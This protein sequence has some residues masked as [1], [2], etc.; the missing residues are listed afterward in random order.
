MKTKSIFSLVAILAL[1]FS[2]GKNK[3]ITPSA[4]FAPYIS[5]YTGGQISSNSSI[6]IE[7]AKEFPMV[8]LNSEVKES[9]FSFSPSLKGKAYWINNKTI[10]FVPDSG[11]LQRGKLYNA[12]FKLGKVAEVEKKLNVFPFSFQVIEQN[13]AIE[14]E[15]YS[16][17]GDYDTEHAM[18]EGSLKLSDAAD[19]VQVKKMLSADL[20]G[21]GKLPVKVEAT[22]DLK[23]YHFTIENIP[24]KKE[25]K[26]LE[27]FA[28]GNPIEVNRSQK[29]S[30]LIP[31][32]GSFRFLSAS[33][34][35][36]P[37][38]GIEIV[39]SDPISQTQ[40]LTGLISLSEVN[41]FTYQIDKNKV[42]LFFEYGSIKNV[43]LNIEGTVKNCQ[44]KTLGKPVSLSLNLES[45]K[46]KVEIPFSG[47]ILPDSKNLA[48][49][50]KAVNLW[51]VD[52]RIVQIY[53]NNLLTFFQTN[54]L[55]SS[56][57]LRRFGRL[58]FKKTL[59]LDGDPAKRL[60]RWENFS[61]D[62]SKII[63]Q[64][65]GAIYRIELSFKKEYSLYPC[66]GVVPKKLT[67]EGLTAISPEELDEKEMAEWDRTSP[68]YYGSYYE[69]EDWYDYRWDEQDDPC[70]SSYYMNSDLKASCNVFASNMGI[71]VK[72]NS[73]KQMW[74]TVANIL[75]AKPMSGT[76][77]KIYNYQ[78]Q[79]IGSGKTDKDG[80]ATIE[81]NPK[82][83]KPFIAYAESGNEKA[84]LRLVDGEEKS[85]SRFDVGGKE[86][87][88]GLK[89]YIYGER[90]V[91]RPGDTVHLGFILEDKQKKI[92]ANHPVT[93]EI[94][95]PRGQF[96][97]KHISTE[98]LNGFYRFDIPTR[99]D[100]PTGLWS[101][102]IKIGGNTF[103]KSLR[104]ETVKPN[105]L[106]VNLEI[107]SSII[108]ASSGSIDATLTSNWLTGATARNLKAKVEM[109]FSKVNVPFKGYESYVF[110]NP[111]SRLYSEN[112]EIF[113]GALNEEGVARFSMRI[114]QAENAPG[115]LKATL[116]SRVFEPGGD[117]SIY[118]QTAPFSPFSSYVGIDFHQK[119]DYEFLETDKDYSFD[120]VTLNPQGKPV[121]AQDLDYR[122]YK[123][124]WNWWW[125][126][127]S[128]SLESYV[129]NNSI[130]PVISSKVSTVNGKAKV[131][132]RIDYPEWGRYLVFVK[133]KASGHVSGQVIYMDWPSYRGRSMKNDPSGLTMYTF[134]TDKP[135][136]EVGEEVTVIL[137]GSIAGRALVALENGSSVLKREWVDISPKGDTK[138]KFKITEDM[139][140]NFYIHASLLQPHAQTINDLPI[141][142]YGVVPVSVSNKNSVLNPEII[143]PDVLRPE[144][145]FTVQ[146]KEKQGRAMTY[147]LAIVD[148]GLLDLTGFKTPNAW[149]EFYAREALG[150]RTWDMYDFVI[151]AFGSKFA[152]LLSIGGDEAMRP[153]NTKANRFKPVVKYLGPFTI[154]KG[155]TAS[156]KIKLPMYVG[157]VR[158]MV[159]AGQDGAYG[160]AEK[161]TPVRNPLMI[162]TTLPRVVSVG[163]EILLPVTVFA[164][165]NSVKNVSVKVETTG[166]MKLTESKAASLQFNKPGD[167]MVYFRIKAGSTTGVETVKITASGN[168]QTASETI[169][170]DVRNP[171]PPI[172]NST[173]K[174]I[175]A[176]QEE[177][178]SYDLNAPSNENWV[179]LQ[180]SRIPS[181]DFGRRFDFLINYQHYCSEQITST[182]FPLLYVEQFKNV[183]AKESETI[184]KNI[185][186]AIKNL[187]SRQLSDGS[188]AYW[189]GQ[190]YANEWVTTYAGHFMYE[191]KQK[192]YE[193][194]DNFIK[195]WLSYQQKMAKEWRA[196]SSKQGY[197]DYYTQSDLQQAYRLYTLA[198][199]GKPDQGAMNRM[200]E[201]PNLSLQA[202]WRLAS[203]YALTGKKR[204]ASEL[205]FNIET[206]VQ[207]YSYNNMTYGSSFR[208]NA[209]I[210]ETLL[211]LDNMQKAWVQA[212]IVSE[213]LTN[214][215]YFST[216]ST[217]FALIAMG[218][219]AEKFS[220]GMIEFEWTINGKAQKV[221]KS[222]RPV[223]EI[224]IPANVLRGDVK[225]KNIGNG[226]LFVTLTSKYKP[227]MDTL[228]ALDNN[229]KTDVR[230]TDLNGNPFEIDN[231]KQGSDF[232]AWV[233]ISNISGATDYSD[234]AL[235]HIIPS[236]W[237]IFNERMLDGEESNE[238]E[239]YANYAYR[240]IRD[241]RVLTYFNLSRGQ[242]KRFKVRMQA[243]YVGRFVL[244][245]I[246]C[247]G[248][249]DTQAQSR[250]RSRWIEVS[251]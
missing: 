44:N 181:V 200:K 104:I 156:H 188:I 226:D 221:V 31:A 36:L 71:I 162:L 42:K 37:E 112:I 11:Q 233:T 27:I 93:L 97:S 20:E 240:D 51:A 193:V 242:Y 190:T 39:F 46:P 145:E 171:N 160:K 53:E 198:L 239:A 211:L 70:K 177:D 232:V 139:A 119:S 161:T 143:M 54:Q 3:P 111:G 43:S 244:P 90:G 21:I 65:P 12:K 199:A 92:P 151:G 185:R 79:V 29:E 73:D 248:M 222:A 49:P 118:V 213:A 18:V 15:A 175:G 225:I 224:N 101:A 152:S 64:E 246:L 192:G 96:Y 195:K 28:D 6:R 164:M 186:E 128:E 40:D 153:S 210:L 131:K 77:V 114:P 2:C 98:G 134:S 110:N 182:T 203:A 250:T 130:T 169:E 201:L 62:L 135:S 191:A 217:A 205:V 125:Q 52:L 227:V 89:G 33:C 25:D 129:Y 132:F 178:F 84:Y 150:I 59:R 212:K 241:D 5:A 7:F 245:A 10:E 67:A 121:N 249:Y 95:N 86:I 141:R 197:Y 172:I 57:E 47:T 189:P 170:I 69:D 23:E 81:L 19:S 32:A 109:T 34:I 238:S 85:L 22:Q 196:P 103:H 100:D 136:Y 144:K 13:F 247:E 231:V 149:D 218:K 120:I 124:S 1:L 228:P 209:M 157:S 123:L 48:L 163:E 55:S 14:T 75:D 194:S 187:Y 215:N 155:Q 105:R 8:E 147:T 133:N 207:G 58:V 229:L 173:N 108:D 74:V 60:D 168:G 41:N 30:I 165:E 91:W 106:K 83:G 63:Q 126:R 45:L 219:F 243:S 80:F 76:T 26:T 24:R 251:K 72:G 179:K 142:M 38:N 174:L 148:D 206:R 122:V 159:V 158:T 66:S 154:K 127:N 56:N 216:Q 116:V 204:A 208:D 180:V 16:C 214:E 87:Q 9:L 137:P 94:F 202:K 113:D 35:H 140:P 138:Y 235:T 115:M 237:E 220:Q 88:R 61:M 146:I 184:K 183:D 167:E 236:G 107:P 230:Y 234:L 17:M 68:Y 50:F 99:M 102:Y 176:S 78:L 223:Y 82:G 117:A 166:L 4:E